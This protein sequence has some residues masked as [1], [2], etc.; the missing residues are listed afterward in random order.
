LKPKIVSESLGQ[1]SIGIAL[2]TCS[3]VT[4]SIVDTRK[5]TPGLRALEKYAVRAG[6]G[7]NHRFGLFDAALINDYHL[8]A[9][10]DVDVALELARAAVVPDVMVHVKVDSLDQIDPAV[11]A[12]ADAVLLDNM[13]L[14]DLEAG[15]AIVA[16]RCPTEA[17][18]GITRETVAATAAT[19][20]D[21]LSV[22]W[23]TLS[24]LRLDVALD[25]DRTWTSCPGAHDTRARPAAGDPA[26]GI[27]VT[28]PSPPSA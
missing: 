7:A 9:V 6:G 26:Y 22:G 16:G 21:R 3:H 15:V 28:R 14:A 12:G 17:S 10:G 23:I 20:V 19:G 2:D 27:C 8:V 1:S 5:T 11:T 24:A 25:L 13:S 4:G 18:G